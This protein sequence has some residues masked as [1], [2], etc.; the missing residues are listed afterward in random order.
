LSKKIFSFEE[1]Q[2]SVKLMIPMTK[3]V[4]VRFNIQ[5][6]LIQ[7]SLFSTPINALISSLFVLYRFPFNKSKI[8]RINC[9]TEVLENYINYLNEYWLPKDLQYKLVKKILKFKNIY[10]MDFC[11]S[12]IV[13]IQYFFLHKLKNHI[14]C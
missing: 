7:R 1:Y 4:L 6:I 2:I 3:D 12:T 5:D 14:T 10:L 8:D 9:L 11:L 13:F